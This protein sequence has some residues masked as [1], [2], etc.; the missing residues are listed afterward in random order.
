[1]IYKKADFIKYIKNYKSIIYLFI[2]EIIF[3]TILAS[4]ICIVFT[5]S[6]SVP[7]KLCLLIYNLKPHKGDLCAFKFKNRRFIKYIL[8]TAGDRISNVQGIISVGSNKVGK[9]QV[10]NNLTPINEG[11][12]PDGYIFVAGTHPDS[13]DS[14]YKE[15]GLIREA[16]LEG[17]VYGIMR[18][19][20]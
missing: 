4:Q 14:R 5:T 12:I 3:I 15:F 2:L 9:V 17:K 13:F 8:G 11:I 1:M 7:Y 16:D 20:Q 19:E 18:Y 10:K 6:P